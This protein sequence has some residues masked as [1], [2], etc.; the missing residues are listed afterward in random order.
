[1]GMIFAD[2]IA[3]HAGAFL[4]S[5]GGIEAQKPHGMHQPAMDRLQAIARVRQ[6]PLGDGGERIGQVAFGQRPHQR[7]GTNV[8]FFY[9]GAHGPVLVRFAIR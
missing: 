7:L 8:V 4:E 1:M 5:G 9:G 2:D 3:H 6:R